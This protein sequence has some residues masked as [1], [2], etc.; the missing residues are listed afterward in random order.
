MMDSRGKLVGGADEGT[1]VKGIAVA[2]GP[3]SK[4]ALDADIELAMVS[5]D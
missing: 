5:I 3:G 4:E 2:I 1:R